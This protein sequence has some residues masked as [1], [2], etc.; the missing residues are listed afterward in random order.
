MA[1]ENLGQFEVFSQAQKN[2]KFKI[3]DN[4][5][6]V[7]FSRQKT[8]ILNATKTKELKDSNLFVKSLETPVSHQA[9]IPDIL[10]IASFLDFSS[11]IKD[12]NL[13]KKTCQKSSTVQISLKT[14]PI[15]KHRHRNH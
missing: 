14:K 12:Y 2:K 9:K 3:P 8:K 5:C 10:K 11:S 1:V 6:V 7:K 15:E 13:I 4:S